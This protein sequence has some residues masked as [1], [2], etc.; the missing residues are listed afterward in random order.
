MKSLNKL[1]EPLRTA[2]LSVTENV[3][4]YKPVDGTKSHIVY[5]EDGAKNLAGNNI[6]ISQVIQ[7]SIDLYELGEAGMFDK[8][9][10]ALNQSNIAFYLNSVQFEEGEMKGFIHYEWIFEVA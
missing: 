6:V 3:G 10:A 4:H 5:A 7:G 1:L 8:V 2:L 9:Q